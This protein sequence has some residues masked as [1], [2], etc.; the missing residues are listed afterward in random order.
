MGKKSL[1]NVTADLSALAAASFRN[2]SIG[3]R[4]I[5]VAARWI[6]RPCCS[7]VT[8]IA[9]R[10]SMSARRFSAPWTARTMAPS[11]GA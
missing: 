6:A 10:P 2:V 4:M 5:F 9:G 7:G 11:V 3:S 8:L 1:E